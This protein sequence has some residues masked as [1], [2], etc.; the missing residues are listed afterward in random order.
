M[1]TCFT[2]LHNRLFL[3]LVIVHTIIPFFD[4][5]N[6][7][8]GVSDGDSGGRDIANRGTWKYGLHKKFSFV[9]GASTPIQCPPVQLQYVAGKCT[10]SLNDILMK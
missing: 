7:E 1:V 10:K 8:N 3:F 4:G 6:G 2:S 9:C 5:D